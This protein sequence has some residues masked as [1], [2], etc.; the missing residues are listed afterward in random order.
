MERKI[1]QDLLK[2]KNSENRKTLVLQGAR[3]VGKIYIVNLFGAKNYAN[4][5]YCNF[6]KEQRL[7]DFFTDFVPQNILKS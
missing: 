2:W 7:K 5:V 4:V 3:Q 6:K 1:Y